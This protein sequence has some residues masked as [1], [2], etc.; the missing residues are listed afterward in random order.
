MESPLVNNRILYVD[1]EENLLH[2]F[3]SMMR[4]DHLDIHL[5]AHSEQIDS[6][7]EEHGPFAVVLS[8]QRMPVMDGVAVLEKTGLSSPETIRILMTGY[9]DFEDT[10]RAINTAGISHY[11]QKPWNDE[12]LRSLVND[13][14]SRYN[15]VHENKLL[16]AQILARNTELTELL[17]GTMTSVVKM[18]LDLLGHVN[19]FAVEQTKRIQ[20]LANATLSLLP[21]LSPQEQRDTLLAFQLFNVGLA[22]LPSLIQV[23][24]NKDGMASIDRF[25]AARNH[26]LLGYELLK[27]IPRFENVARIILLSGKNID[28]SGEPTVELIGGNNLPLGSRILHIL[29]DMERSR[30]SHFNGKEILQSFLSYRNKY[31]DKILQSLLG[32][33]PERVVVKKESEVMVEGLLPEMTVTDN[34]ISQSNQLLLQRGS[35]LTPS[36]VSLLQHWHRHD[37]INEPIAVIFPNAE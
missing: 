35:V 11:I 13:A 36:T 8:D 16:S 27:D 14:V 7:L 31:D 5:L 28:G 32:M 24:I 4:K 30:S 6:V 23:A 1:D 25:P 2:S 26:H 20:K 9:A 37:P 34:V 17:D 3:R 33:A 15:L 10:K 18:L 19:P 12:S 22:A 21:P 29:T